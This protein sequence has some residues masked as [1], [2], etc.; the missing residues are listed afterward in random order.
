MR[1]LARARDPCAHKPR[2]VKGRD[3]SKGFPV[4]VGESKELATQNAEAAENIK[5]RIA[6]M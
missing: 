4:V 3:R 6:G 5:S 2:I 1:E